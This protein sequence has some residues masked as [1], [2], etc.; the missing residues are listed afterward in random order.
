MRGVEIRSANAIFEG[1]ASGLSTGQGQAGLGWIR[2]GYREMPEEF[3]VPSDH[4][5]L[6]SRC[7]FA[8]ISIEISLVLVTTSVG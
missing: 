6:Y 7:I 8:G 4:L 2:L 1:V 5:A 3:R